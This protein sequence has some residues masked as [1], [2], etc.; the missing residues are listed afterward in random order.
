M[1]VE[2]KDLQRYGVLLIKYKLNVAQT[3][4]AFCYKYKGLYF[5]FTM[6]GGELVNINEVPLSCTLIEGK[7]VRR[8][9]YEEYF[10]S[11]LNVA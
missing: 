3:K 5:D 11:S 8:K 9:Y 7:K 2:L 6:S 1:R 10:N 4:H